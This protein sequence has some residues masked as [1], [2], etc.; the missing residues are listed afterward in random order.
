MWAGRQNQQGARAGVLIQGEG[1]SEA[2]GPVRN[3]GLAQ[4]S[5]NR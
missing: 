2:L 3:A 1:G 5:V 4:M